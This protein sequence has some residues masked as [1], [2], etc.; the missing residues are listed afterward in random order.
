MVKAWL[1]PSVTL[2]VP[3]GLIEPPAPAEATIVLVAGVG[4]GVGVGI[5][6]VCGTY[7]SM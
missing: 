1:W 4:V 5:V 7:A 3:L 6:V 2:T